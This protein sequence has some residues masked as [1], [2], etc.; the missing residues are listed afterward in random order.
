[1]EV[2]IG[3]VVNE[4]LVAVFA[5]EFPWEIPHEFLSA[6]PQSFGRFYFSQ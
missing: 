1:M 6:V 3:A 4:S 2:K 5:T